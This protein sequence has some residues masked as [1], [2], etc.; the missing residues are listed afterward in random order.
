MPNKIIKIIIVESIDTLGVGYIAFCSHI[1][2]KIN[3]RL[4][5]LGFTL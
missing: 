4:Y 1:V 3:C 2:W 5:I